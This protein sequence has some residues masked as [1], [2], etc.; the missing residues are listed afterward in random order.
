MMWENAY[1]EILRMKTKEESIIQ[2]VSLW[3]QKYKQ[4]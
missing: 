1:D 3:F 4:A 2:N